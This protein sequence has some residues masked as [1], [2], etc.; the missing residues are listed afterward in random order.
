MGDVGRHLAD[1]RQLLHAHDDFLL[2]AEPLV[3][4]R[5]LA[6]LMAQA[7]VEGGALNG[8]GDWQCK[9]FKAVEI[10]LSDRRASDDIIGEKDADA[11]GAAEEGD[12]DQLTPSRGVRPAADRA[13][14]RSRAEQYAPTGDSPASR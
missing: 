4:F 12:E 3:R 10:I 7:L 8:V 6:E 14:A 5:Q 1:Q 13:P 2:G 9:G 11:P